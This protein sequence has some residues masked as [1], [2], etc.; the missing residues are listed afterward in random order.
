MGQKQQIIRQADQCVKCGLC[1]P[2]CPTYKL[3]SEE[4]YSPRG[5][6]SL[7]QGMAHG[8]LSPEDKQ[9]QKFLD[10]C[11]GCRY[12]ET[13]CPS[14]VEYHSLLTKTR[15]VL[16]DVDQKK[17][18]LLT[19]IAQYF[20][21]HQKQFKKFYIILWGLQRLG[22]LKLMT[23]FRLG[24][25]SSLQTIIWM[26]PKL[27]IFKANGS[28]VCSRNTQNKINRVSLFTG[29]TGRSLG[30]ATLQSSI[31]CLQML[32]YQ[33]SVPED[34]NCCGLLHRHQGEVDHA[35]ALVQ[36]NRMAFGNEQKVL[37]FASGCQSAL[38]EFLKKFNI[39]RT[40]D[41]D[42]FQS[43]QDI[44]E[45]LVENH[46]QEIVNL[47]NKKRA[48]HV[49]VHRP[50]TQQYMNEHGVLPL[51]RAIP[52]MTVTVAK[53]GQCCGAAGSN[54]LTQTSIA[55]KLASNIINEFSQSGATVFLSSNIGCE[56][57]LRS[58]LGALNDKVRV[59]HPLQFL[60]ENMS[61]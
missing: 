16:K 61:L 60:M 8:D 35:D 51:L 4:G 39:D 28:Y 59:M 12:C 36:K 38:R 34:Q 55:S 13:V 49:F 6:I 32:G 15:A 7:M 42:F 52:G 11:L 23:L 14:K 25:K 46:F 54:F 30:K 22:V 48:C 27:S 3:M 57:H 20:L 43:I 1:L 44:G 26:L 53:N 24:K 58:Q 33:I 41:S 47:A 40:A 45:F 10:T 5:R 2:H 21:L 18:S 9:V 31:Q 17:G 50:C 19:K 56:L 37:T 29:C